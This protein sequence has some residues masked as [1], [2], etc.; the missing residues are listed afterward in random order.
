MAKAIVW[1]APD[2]S[3]R[4][5]H[6]NDKPHPWGD[7]PLEGE[8]EQHYLDRHAMI[9]LSSDPSLKECT[10]LSDH[11][12][13]ALPATRRWRNCWRHDG[14]GVAIDLA[15]TKEQRLAEIR[16]ERNAALDGTDKDMARLNE[17]GTAEQVAAM[18]AYRQQLRD[19]PATVQP[20]L[21]KSATPD[22][23]AELPLWPE[24]PS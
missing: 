7:P 16:L 5:T 10:R 1:Q 20:D 2:G 24:K 23:V 8:T 11:D 21:D 14:K 12:I 13:D 4:I 9:A 15:L 6:P 3:L 17:I 19:I 22:E 18:K